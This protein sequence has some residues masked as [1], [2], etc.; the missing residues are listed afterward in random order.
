M[1]SEFVPGSGG[2]KDVLAAGTAVGGGT[3]FALLPGYS[4]YAPY[5][6][7]LSTSAA[8]ISL[9]SGAGQMTA[10]SS[11]VISSFGNGVSINWSAIGA[12]KAPTVGEEFT[13]NGATVQVTDSANSVI[14]ATVIMASLPNADGGT[15][16]NISSADVGGLALGEQVTIGAGSTLAAGTYTLLPAQYALLPGAYLITPQT[17]TAVPQG[18]SGTRIDGATMVSGYYGIAGTTS[19]SQ[20]PAEFVV[21]AGS[22]ALANSQINVTYGDSFFAKQAATDNLAVPQLAQDAGQLSAIVTTALELPT[23]ITSGALAAK[24][25]IS[26]NNISVVSAYDGAAGVVELLASDLKKYNIG[27]LFLGGVRSVDATTGNTVF[28]VNASTVTVNSG[29]TLNQASE[30]ILAANNTLEVKSGATLES[31]GTAG[32]AANTVIETGA[33]SALLRVANGPQVVLDR[34]GTGGGTGN[35]LI[36]SGATLQA[37]NTAVSGAI[38]LDATG[39][40]SSLQG[41]ISLDNHGSLT[42]GA[43]ALN[44]G[45]T[46]NQTGLSGL[47]IDQTQL[48]NLGNIANLYLTGRNYID[49][50]GDIYAQGNTPTQIGNLVLNT[51]VLAGISVA[52]DS[53]AAQFNASKLTLANYSGGTCSVGSGSA[54]SGQGSETLTFNVANL[55]LDATNAGGF[56]V[57]GFSGATNTPVG[58]E[59]NVGKSVTGVAT[60][61]YNFTENTV[62]N[63]PVISADSAVNTTIN[64]NGNNLTIA[65]TQQG[66]GADQGVGATLNLSAANLSVDSSLLYLGGNVNL[67]ASGNLDL[68]SNTVIDVSAS[69]QAAGLNPA[70]QIAAGEISL[71]SQGDVLADAGAQLLLNSN[72]TGIAAGSLHINA[73]NASYINSNTKAPSDALNND[74]PI[75]WLGDAAQIDAK[76][77]SSAYGGQ[78]QMYVNSFDTSLGV[79][80][81]SPF[82]DL[83]SLATAAGFSGQ[84]NLRLHTGDIN[85]YN[86]Q[87]VT[88]QTI[89]LT[90]DNGAINVLGTLD[91]AGTNGGS[92]TLSSNSAVHVYGSLLAN[93]QGAA[94]N[95]GNVTLSAVS[96]VAWDNNGQT[97]QFTPGNVKIMHGAVVD[98]LSQGD[99]TQANCVTLGLCGSLGSVHLLVDAQVDNNTGAILGVTNNGT[100][101]I[102]PQG[103]YAS[104]NQDPTNPALQPD[105]IAVQ[106]YDLS[107]PT[108]QAG[109]SDVQNQITANDVLTYQTNA[110]NFMANLSNPSSH[111]IVMP[112]IEVITTG[113]KAMTVDPGAVWDLSTWRYSYGAHTNLP[114]ELI[115]RSSGDLNIA[116]SLT[117]GF[118]NTLT[119]NSYQ[120]SSV[121]QF[122]T[123][124]GVTQLQSGYSWSYDLVAGADIASADHNRTLAAATAMAANAGN[125]NLQTFTSTVTSVVDSTDFNVSSTV[126]WAV[127][128]SLVGGGLAAGTVITGISG[129]TVSINLAPLTSITHNPSITAIKQIYTGTGD[130][131]VNAAGNVNMSDHS[132]I[133]TV[134][135]QDAN[136]AWGYSETQAENIYY[137]YSNRD[138][139]TGYYAEYPVDGGNV[140]VNA[141][142]SIQVNLLNSTDKLSFYTDWMMRL[143][144][145]IAGQTMPVAWGVNFENYS[146]NGA[147]LGTL[148]GGNIIVN[149]GNNIDNLTVA[150]PTTG[151]INTTETVASSVNDSGATTLTLQNTTG[152]SVGD[153]ISG[154]GLDPSTVITG[155]NGNTITLSTATT[156]PILA[157]E[158]IVGVGVTGTSPIVSG[159]GNLTVNSGGNI[160]GGAFYVE[161][162][163]AN[164]VAAGSLTA[165][166]YY[167]TLGNVNAYLDPILALGNAQI[168][169]IAGQNIALESV[170]NP[171]AVP[172]PTANANKYSSFQDSLFFTYGAN[173]GVSLTA[174][175]GN[176]TLD[177][178]LTVLEN[179]TDI[180]NSAS[181][182]NDLTTYPGALTV[183][184]L[185]GSI[186][187]LNSFQL[188]PTANGNLNLYAYDNIDTGPAS[189]VTQQVTVNLSAADPASLPSTLSPVRGKFG[190]G[191]SST[192]NDPL[193]DLSSIAAYAQT[194]IHQNDNNPVLI[195]TAIGS[196][197][198]QSAQGLLF[199]LAKQAIVSAG[200][201]IIDTG[202]SIQQDT[203]ASSSLISAGRDIVFNTARDPATGAL[204]NAGNNKIIQVS[205]PGQLTVTSGRNIDL[206]SSAGIV[207]VGNTGVNSFLPNGGANLTVLAGLGGGLVNVGGF[208]QTFSGLIPN[209]VAQ[210]YNTQLDSYS[211]KLTAL[212]RDYSGNQNMTTAQA[213]SYFAQ[214]ANNPTP[215][216]QFSLSDKQWLGTIETQL[217]QYVQPI[218]AAQMQQYAQQRAAATL[219]VDKDRLELAMMATTEALYPGTTLLAGNTNYHYDPTLG[220]VA[221]AGSNVSDIIKNIDVNLLAEIQAAYGNTISLGGGSSVNISAAEQTINNSPN[222]AY[223]KSLISSIFAARPDIQAT[224]RPDKGDLSLY[225][226]T[227]QTYDGGNINI[228]T[229]NG[230]IDAGLSASTLGQKSADQL[231]IIVRGAGDINAFLRND[232]QVNLTRV[233]TLGGG[234]VVAGSSEGSIDAGKGVALNGAVTQQV[235]YDIYGNPLLTLLP[236]V[237][238]SGIRSASPANSNILPGS[239]VLFAPRGVIDAGEAG[240][241]GGNLYLDA[242]SFKNVANISSTGI[243]IGAPAS[244]PPAGISASLSGASGLTASV[245]KS[246]ESATDAVGKDSDENRLKKAMAALGVLLV[247]VLGF[248][249]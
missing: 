170:L 214:L 113:G 237:T 32:T 180:P 166:S 88:A 192:S 218:Y 37:G 33:A 151:K 222:S 74:Q 5:D 248:G 114:G 175:S 245:N 212:M 196:I 233:M 138:G 167:T 43:N 225:F 86:T 72:Y 154:Q 207:S 228:Q 156:A 60:G 172:S 90:A 99:Y 247:D 120:S 194:P 78:L 83:N 118:Y 226:S 176:V 73:V 243:S 232:F 147:S 132:M 244:A 110:A 145:S 6:P 3:S 30:L 8:T 89:N 179:A 80:P 158:S 235:T 77:P 200:L 189:S 112:G 209:S 103:Y 66:G 61:V 219:T 146:T 202:F 135:R 206:G 104:G 153:A 54:C 242:S 98:V 11:Y 221:N 204:L 68:Q 82:N 27:S 161:Q 184:A 24:I 102:V 69:Q 229:P 150:I 211:S 119:G 58:V 22:A 14:P 45:D 94:G 239:I 130:I 241:A 126:D 18:W 213:L 224:I 85:V 177:N 190:Q 65:S 171:L 101:S 34:S 70:V 173:S 168:N 4:G 217:L 136:N 131:T 105:V 122:N 246:F 220:W 93:A 7:L 64:A 181:V 87:V 76:G 144:G 13:Y 51:P 199:A 26:A 205:G 223:G 139:T 155:I 231:G 227:I 142:N 52:G 182:L 174:V 143:S 195:S 9:G 165:G 208:A 186:N 183:N 238:T 164:I 38:L 249:D 234:S 198:S 124:T 42:I 109:A 159:G 133:Y 92:I 108:S 44:I 240:I 57:S 62:I 149:A 160:A 148:G 47:S 15:N 123:D 230:G 215:S 67:N 210:A 35:L 125:V 163:I 63:T 116:Q 48:Y 20:T 21:Q 140:T 97:G 216:T 50:Y 96:Q 16:I 236:A 10:G 31:V 40:S 188:F 107:L 28:N 55:V 36:D 79:N 201:D 49:V 106:V 193:T 178:N 12:G 23:L 203:A 75:V 185:Q 81:S 121:N 129:N 111:F 1:A 46:A 59:F 141:G 2:S 100:V 127:G 39:N 117:D 71:T 162:G 53:N 137:V 84:F 152:W 187:V 128:D 115:L 169:V 95:G 19:Q 134:G 191:T 197:E 41:K 29:V 25:D 56:S 91:A 17:T 157:G